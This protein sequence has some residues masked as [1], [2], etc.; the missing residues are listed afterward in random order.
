MEGKRDDHEPQKLRGCK[1]TRRVCWPREAPKGKGGKGFWLAHSPTARP[2]K[3]GE[4][5]PPSNLP[6]PA[7]PAHHAHLVFCEESALEAKAPWPTEC[8]PPSLS[9]E[10]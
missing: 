10:S 9:A 1:R 7:P 2:G 3:M 5:G 4:A 6:V 8:P